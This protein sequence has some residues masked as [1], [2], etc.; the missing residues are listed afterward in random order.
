M[1]SSSAHWWSQIPTRKQ[2]LHEIFQLT[3]PQSSVMICEVFLIWRCLVFISTVSQELRRRSDGIS[4][5]L[6][7]EQNSQ[8]R[9]LSIFL[10]VLWNN[11]HPLEIGSQNIQSKGS[12]QKCDTFLIFRYLLFVLFC[13]VFLCGLKRQE[14]RDWCQTQRLHLTGMMSPCPCCITHL[15]TFTCTRTHTCTHAD[16]RRAFALV[17]TDQE[18]I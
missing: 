16:T 4:K 3:W 12:R 5:L 17:L 14:V 13:S 15:L 10:Y 18:R 9:C 8:I 1:T 6:K 7:L 11:Y 2:H